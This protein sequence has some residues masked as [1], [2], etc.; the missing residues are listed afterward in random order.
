MMQISQEI[1]TQLKKQKNNQLLQVLVTAKYLDGYAGVSYI[2]N[3]DNFNTDTENLNGI[4]N[5][6]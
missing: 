5:L 2:S 6:F 3:W 4:N 1:G